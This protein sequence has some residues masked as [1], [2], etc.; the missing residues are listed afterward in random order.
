LGVV[1]FIASECGLA[2]MQSS[3]IQSIVLDEW[4][5]I[6]LQLLSSAVAMHPTY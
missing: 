5:S 1:Y 6:Q 3:I 4:R 2:N